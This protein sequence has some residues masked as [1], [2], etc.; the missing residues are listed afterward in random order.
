MANG[1]VF[2]IDM[3]IPGIFKPSDPI[4]R[5]N[6]IKI[7]RAEAELHKVFAAF[8]LTRL[9]IAWI[10]SQFPQRGDQSA[11]VIHAAVDKQV[12]I[13]RRIRKPEQDC[14]RFPDE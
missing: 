9:I 12:S 6:E 5:E 10:E 4:T 2:D 7:E 13:R 1:K 14:A 11:S 3:T 8:N